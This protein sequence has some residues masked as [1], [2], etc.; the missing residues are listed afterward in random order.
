MLIAYDTPS[1][2][3]RRQ[4]VKVLDD[5]GCRIQYSVFQAWMNDEQL[6]VME[7][8]IAQIVCSAEDSIFIV[9]LNKGSRRLVR[10]YGL[11]RI[12][13]LPEYWIV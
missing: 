11:A 4:L 2:T 5:F 10:T 3:R 13:Q 8:R 7:R 1:D 9:P 6:T 12:E